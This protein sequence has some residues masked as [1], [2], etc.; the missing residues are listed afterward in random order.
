M[1]PALKYGISALALSVAMSLAHAQTPSRDAHSGDAMT[2]GSPQAAQAESSP[3]DN[4]K[5]RSDRQSAPHGAGQ[6]TREGKS[7]RLD[8]DR[9]A[10]NE[11]GAGSKQRDE[12]S[13]MERQE[14]ARGS[15]QAQNESKPSE[16]A[17]GSR[18]KQEEMRRA[19]PENSASDNRNA[20]ANERGNPGANG[21]AGRTHLAINVSPD[22]RTKIRDV[23]IHDTSIHRIDRS[24]VHFA[25]NVGTIV[26]ATVELYPV[27]ERVLVIDPDFRGYRVILVGD[28][29]L[30]VD[31]DTRE[32]LDVI[33]V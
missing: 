31:P 19:Q 27:P 18:D 6:P 21:R 28:V 16:E 17:G 12:K 5:A 26:P 33:E 9:N 29:L 3:A 23:V 32:I 2:G 4:S 14:R 24:D 22:Q 10:A 20:N 1:N 7:G 8:H 25:L 15:K 11:P 30:I 13:A